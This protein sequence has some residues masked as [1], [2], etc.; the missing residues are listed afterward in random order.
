[1][2]G[3]KPTGFTIIATLSVVVFLL[4]ML[5]VMVINAAKLNNYIKNNVRFSVFF[6]SGISDKEAKTIAD[7][8]S[9]LEFVANSKFISSEDAAFNFKKEIGEDFVEILGNNPLPASVELG[10]KSGYTQEINLRQLERRLAKAHGV[11]EV[12][13][14][15]NVMHQIDRNRRAIVL[16]LGILSFLF[17]AISAVLINNTIRLLIYSDQFL[18]KNQQL[19]GAS[20]DFILK[21]YRRKAVIWI[22]VSFLSGTAILFLLIWL[23]FVWLNVSLDLNMAAITQL[24]SESWYQYLLM[25]FLLLAIGAVVIY[26]TTE[27]ATR[28]YLNTHTDNLY[29]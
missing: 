18:I 12:S 24:F 16:W 9:K 28:K 23:V 29:N 5:G 8:L 2:N 4:G 10:V 15:Q 14:P 22:I 26:G 3:S 1:M 19:I 7:S 13:Y 20:E 11:L 27:F 21:P 25:L 6:Q 17:V